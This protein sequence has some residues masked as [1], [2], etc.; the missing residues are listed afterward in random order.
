MPPG[1]KSGEYKKT[2]DT[3]ALRPILHIPYLLRTCLVTATIKTMRFFSRDSVLGLLLQ[4]VPACAAAQAYPSATV[5]SRLMPDVLG[6]VLPLKATITGV[7]AVDLVALQYCGATDGDGDFVAIVRPSA[8]GTSPVAAQLSSADCQRPLR[9]V[10]NSAVQNA[11][12]TTP[13]SSALRLRS[14]FSPWMLTLETRQADAGR[15]SGNSVKNDAGITS[16][17]ATASP[18]VRI[19]TADVR[20]N[21]HNASPPL[22]L[23]IQPVGSVLALLGSED[24]S[25]PPASLASDLQARLTAGPA[26]ATLLIRVPYAFLANWANAEIQ[27]GVTV[28]DNNGSFTFSDAVVSGGVGK[29]RLETRAHE[30]KS[31]S[32][33]RLVYEWTGDNLHL[34][35]VSVQSIPRDCSALS[36]FER[37]GC[38]VKNTFAAGLAAAFQTQT[39]NR[40][41]GS[42]MRPL[43][44]GNPSDFA[45]QSKPLRLD[46]ETLRAEAG[47]DA[48]YLYALAWLVNP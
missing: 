11:P 17:L 41:G 21:S 24:G 14:H 19:P 18:F 9:Q 26:N 31:D 10:R 40:I 28:T 36:G 27:R 3:L 44:A 22:H 1:P 29:L 38:I 47:A 32:D 33:F 45:V 4:V 13:W 16:A 48:L 35:S 39:W 6:A 20:L 5:D 43:R 42:R 37:A 30:P 12:A 8:V 2:I 25:V 15:L 23:E 46:A 34:S 7:G